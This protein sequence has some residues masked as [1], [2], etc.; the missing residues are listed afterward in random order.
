MIVL[1]LQ[2]PL[3][4]VDLLLTFYHLKWI[5][6]SSLTPRRSIEKITK[7][8]LRS[9]LM[10]LKISK[11]RISTRSKNRN[12]LMTSWLPKIN[13]TGMMKLKSKSKIKTS[14]KLPATARIISSKTEITSTPATTFWSI[15][16]EPSTLTTLRSLRTPSENLLLS[17]GLLFSIAICITSRRM[18]EFRECLSCLRVTFRFTL[19]QKEATLHLMF[20]CAVKPPQSSLFLFWKKHSN[21]HMSM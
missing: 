4:N 11:T 2:S 18:V 3:E 12:S 9:T 20:S 1:C 14:G 15:C 21:L 5:S 8:Q 16:G 17:R 19:G 6:A 7:K 13:S 10:S